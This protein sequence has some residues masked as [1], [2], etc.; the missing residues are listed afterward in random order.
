MDGGM[1]VRLGRAIRATSTTGYRKDD[2]HLPQRSQVLCEG[3]NCFSAYD[4][5]KEPWLKAPWPIKLYL[6]LFHQ[7]RLLS[8]IIHSF[9]AEDIV[10]KQ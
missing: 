2:H 6:Q 5:S 9:A 7:S 1:D 8:Q 10:H 3:S 4:L